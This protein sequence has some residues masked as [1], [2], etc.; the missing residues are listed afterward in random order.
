MR[1][2]EIVL[3]GD[4]G[5]VIAAGSSEAVYA[6]ARLLQP[7][8]SRCLCKRL[9]CF[10]ENALGPPGCGDSLCWS[11]WGA[12]PCPGREQRRAEFDLV[13]QDFKREFGVK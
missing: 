1:E 2:R 5:R 3:V 12:W 9:H 7:D 4:A 11:A 6:A 8:V 13:L 10:D